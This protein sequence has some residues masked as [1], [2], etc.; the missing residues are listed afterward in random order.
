MKI[1]FIFPILAE[2]H[3]ADKMSR[4]RKLTDYIDAG[5]SKSDGDV[6]G[7]E[8]SNNNNM[9]LRELMYPGWRTNPVYQELIRQEEEWER[10]LFASGRPG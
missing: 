1:I 10:R 9:R 7:S 2:L 6:S 3:Q 8:N 5:F 4:K